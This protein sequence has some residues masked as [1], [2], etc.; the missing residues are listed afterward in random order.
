VNIENLSGSNFD[1]T[2]TGNSTANTLTGGSGNDTLSG[3]AGADTL[4]GGFGNDTYVVDNVADVITE[5]A[6]EGTDMAQSSVTYTLAANVD[7]LTL[8][9]TS[10]IN[11]TGKQSGTIS[12]PGNT[13]NNT[14]TGA[15]GNDTLAGGTGNDRLDG[16]VGN[17]TYRFARG[18]GVDV[19]SDND[20]TAGNSDLAQFAA[21]IA[22]DQLWFRHVGN[23]L[24]VSVIGTSDAL[25]I[26]NWYSGSAYHLERFQTADTKLLV[27]TSV[28][29]LVQAMA[30]FAPPARRRDDAA[31]RLPDGTGA[32]TGGQLAIGLPEGLPEHFRAD[33]RAAVPPTRSTPLLS[34]RGVPPTM[35]DTN[36]LD[37]IP[38]ATPDPVAPETL[39]PEIDSGL[40][41]LVMLARFHA[42]AA[43]PRAT[44]AHVP[45]TRPSLRHPADPPRRPTPRPHGPACAHR[46]PAP[47]PHAAAGAGAS[48][49]NGRFFILARMR[50]PDQGV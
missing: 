28:E 17:D 7:Q 5:N 37:T 48:T 16:G 21:G 1:D 4:I 2:L 23:H 35:T 38:G 11:G 9:G 50:G 29:N 49:G 32:G 12:S 6:G 41:G 19:A 31:A 40:I 33:P 39:P 13:G 27:D 46:I 36:R 34:S 20:A 3:A 22:N 45:R 43:D 10:A 44:R 25:T 42:I 8:T 47:R 26:E 15:L 18:D 30:A 24:E 14:L